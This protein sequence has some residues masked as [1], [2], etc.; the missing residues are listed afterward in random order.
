MSGSLSIGHSLSL[1]HVNPALQRILLRLAVGLLDLAVLA[2][3]Q[4]L[5]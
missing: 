5:W 4:T 1:T 3:V 2:L